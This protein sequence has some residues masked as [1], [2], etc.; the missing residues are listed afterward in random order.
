MADRAVARGPGPVA[1]R[2]PEGRSAG[3]RGGRGR[4]AGVAGRA[5]PD[6]RRL[7]PRA[8]GAD[9]A[10][11]G[12]GGGG[13][14][15]SVPRRLSAEQRPPHRYGPRRGRPDRG[16]A[17]RAGVRAVLRAGR[18]GAPVAAAGRCR[19][20]PGFHRV[21]LGRSARGAE[22]G[23][24]GGAAA[25]L[26]RALGCGPDAS[27]EREA[28]SSGLARDAAGLRRA[29][30]PQRASQPRRGGVLAGLSRRATALGAARVAAGS[31]G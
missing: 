10:C 17:G 3:R 18:H 20:E 26:G 23:C 6:G 7:R 13:G 1:A 11:G 29:R 15:V 19:G 27:R 5:A 9:G 21:S 4:G 28:A 12:S 31:A 14:G 16:P 2:Y 8:G 30:G 22:R 24:L 25:V